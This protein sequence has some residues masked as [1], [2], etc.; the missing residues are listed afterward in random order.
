MN[1]FTRILICIVAYFIVFMG[2]SIYRDL[3]NLY[4]SPATGTQFGFIA[5][6][7]LWFFLPK[8]K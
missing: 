6:F 3:N 2:N 5:M 7:I 8:K 1:V 4:P